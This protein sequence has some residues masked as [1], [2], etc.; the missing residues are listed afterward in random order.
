LYLYGPL[1]DEQEPGNCGTQPCRIVLV[2]V[3]IHEYL[4]TYALRVSA[5]HPSDLGL[6]ASRYVTRRF[7]KCS[8]WASRKPASGNALGMRDRERTEHGAEPVRL[9]AAWIHAN[10]VYELTKVRLAPVQH[11]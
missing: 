1:Y 5:G 8:P 2:E 6:F 4:S 10:L 9:D 11:G 7:L 3:T